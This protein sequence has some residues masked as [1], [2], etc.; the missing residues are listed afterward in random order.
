MKDLNVRPEAVKLLEEHMGK[1][2]LDIGLDNNFWDIT[3]KA[4]AIK[5]KINKQDYA[6]LKRF[7]TAKGTI[8]RMKRQHIKWKEIFANHRSEKV[9]ISKIFKKLQ[10]LNSKKKQQQQTQNPNFKKEKGLDIKDIQWPPG[11]WKGIQHH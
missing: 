10:Q 4:K 7:S 2:L 3:S 5:A 1:K 11:I 6:K 8:N 9:L